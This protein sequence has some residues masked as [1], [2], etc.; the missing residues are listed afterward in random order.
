M[1]SVAGFPWRAMVQN[2]DRQGGIGVDWSQV[3]E[4]LNERCSESS[5]IVG[6]I[7]FSELVDTLQ[8][9]YPHKVARD[10]VL[11]CEVHP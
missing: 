4:K 3:K 9:Y 10:R 1:R 5:E 2:A 11:Q 6:Q 8:Q 7:G